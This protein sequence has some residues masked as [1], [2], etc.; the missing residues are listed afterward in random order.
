WSMRTFRSRWWLPGQIES[1]LERSET[2]VRGTL[3]NNT[4]F[5]LENCWICYGERLH[6]LGFLDAGASL[7]FETSAEKSLRRVHPLAA[8]MVG[9]QDQQETQARRAALD[10]MCARLSRPRLLDDIGSGAYVYPEASPALPKSGTPLFFGFASDPALPVLVNGRNVM[11]RS[12]VLVVAELP[13][14]RVEGW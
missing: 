13:A 3:T 8:E 14:E 11:R 7:R 9:G 6:K 12:A 4:P 2:D 1:D 5:D 10:V